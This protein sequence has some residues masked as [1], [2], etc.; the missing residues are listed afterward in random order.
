[1]IRF[2]LSIALAGFLIV[3]WSTTPAVAQAG[4]DDEAGKV[5]DQKLREAAGRGSERPQE[6]RLEGPRHAF[7]ETSHYQPYNSSWRQ[8]IG[9]VANNLHD[10]KLKEA[11]AGSRSCSIANASCESMPTRSPSRCTKRREIPRK[12]DNIRIFSKAFHATVFAPGH[13][14]SFEK[15]IEVLFID[16]EYACSGQWAAR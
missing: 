10:G 12:P 9:K 3:G 13:G 14:T 8:D 11:E 15:P 7:A 2:R 6:G 16:E 1:M 4:D 5:L